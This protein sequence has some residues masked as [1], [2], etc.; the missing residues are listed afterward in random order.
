MNTKGRIYGI[1]GPVIYI[2]G[3][4]KFR[5]NEMVYVGSEKLVG[6]VITLDKS[7]T[8]IQVFEETAGLSRR[9]SCR[10]RHKHVAYIGPEYLTIYLWHRTSTS[11]YC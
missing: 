11:R 8:T 4:T 2:K 5:M 3:P 10:N 6:E 9:R 1:N 7:R